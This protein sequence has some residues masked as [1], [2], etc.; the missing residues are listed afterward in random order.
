VCDLRDARPPGLT[1]PAVIRVL[2]VCDDDEAE[3]E[4]MRARKAAAQAAL[5]RIEELRAEDW[6]WEDSLD[7]LDR[8][9]EFRRRRLSQRAGALDSED[10]DLDAR[11][12]A[13]Q[14]TV[15]DLLDTQRRV[16]LRDYG[17]IP[18]EILTRS[19]AS[20]TSKTNGLR[21]E[22]RRSPVPLRS[23]RKQQLTP[24]ARA[25]GPATREGRTPV[26]IAGPYAGIPQNG[27]LL[28]QPQ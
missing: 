5:D 2:G 12:Q 23:P 28:G 3:R 24:P 16:R 20:W 6:T 15:R 18:D 21:S 13:Y 7:R 8:Q 25:P 1:L 10:E 14:R 17:Q 4:E 9:H 27:R 26:P 11:S 22:Q 19:R